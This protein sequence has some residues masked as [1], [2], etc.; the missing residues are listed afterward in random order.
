MEGPGQGPG[1]CFVAQSGIQS[2][3]DTGDRGL[4]TSPVQDAGREGVD[5][6][7]G[8]NAVSEEG[9]VAGAEFVRVGHAAEEDVN[10]SLNVGAIDEAIEIN[11]TFDA[12][13]GDR[14]CFGKDGGLRIRVGDDNVP[15]PAVGAAEVELAGHV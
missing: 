2:N 14:E 12:I 3:G 8:D 1:R 11:I 9:D 10:E 6:V 13:D 4:F 7:E 15:G 5:I